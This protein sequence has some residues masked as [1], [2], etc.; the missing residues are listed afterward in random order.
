MRKMAAENEFKAQ[1]ASLAAQEQ[2]IKTQQAR[3]QQERAS[4]SRAQYD[5][6]RVRI[7]SP[8]NGI[9]TRR[10]IEEGETAVLVSFK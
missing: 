4:L 9:V 7:E 2:S 6:S 3:I 5:L 8:I 10:N 1:Q